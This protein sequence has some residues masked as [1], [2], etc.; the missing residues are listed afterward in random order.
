MFGNWDCVYII[1]YNDPHLVMQISFL[2]VHYQ[3]D[4][5][6]VI[7]K[8]P[9]AHATSMRPFEPRR[10]ILAQH[11]SKLF[12]FGIQMSSNRKIIFMGGE[13]PR[14]YMHFKPKEKMTHDC[15]RGSSFRK[16]GSK[17][18]FVLSLLQRWIYIGQTSEQESI[19][20]PF[21]TQV[22]GFISI[23]IG[24]IVSPAALIIF[25]W[26]SSSEI[27]KISRS[28]KRHHGMLVKLKMH[29]PLQKRTKI[30][31]QHHGQKQWL[32]VV[33]AQ[34]S[35]IK[36]KGLS[37]FGWIFADD[38]QRLAPPEKVHPQFLSH[39]IGHHQKIGHDETNSGIVWQCAAKLQNACFCAEY[40]CRCKRVRRYNIYSASPTKKNELETFGSAF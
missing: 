33:E 25:S 4:P 19:P 27:P 13:F 12:S 7:L 2:G 11:I 22:A 20:V 21:W 32:E 6:L 30:C 36:S 17:D 31:V 40:I 28:R 39:H 15:L 37:F 29:L 18:L 3:N 10:E 35:E 16:V 38:L 9:I 5:K 23:L 34:V 1:L 8:S 24:T 14:T 26:R